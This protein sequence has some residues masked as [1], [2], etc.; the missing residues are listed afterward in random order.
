[1]LFKKTITKEKCNEIKNNLNNGFYDKNNDLIYKEI[2]E[3]V[4]KTLSWISNEEENILIK[5]CYINKINQGEFI[6]NENDLNKI[7]IIVI[8]N[9]TIKDEIIS[10]N[11]PKWCYFKLNELKF[12]FKDKKIIYYSFYENKKPFDDE[13][14]LF[15]LPHI[16]KK[17]EEEEIELFKIPD[18]KNKIPLINCE[19]NENN[20][21]IEFDY[22]SIESLFI[23][24]LVLISE[25]LILKLNYQKQYDKEIINQYKNIKKT[26]SLF[27]DKDFNINNEILGPKTNYLLDK[28]KGKKT[29]LNTIRII[30]I[31]IVLLTDLNL[32]NKI[33]YEF[34]NIKTNLIINWLNFEEFLFY[35]D[36]LLL[37]DDINFKLLLN[38][39]KSKFNYQYN[40]LKVNNQLKEIIQYDYDSINNIEIIDLNTIKIDF[41]FYIKVLNFYSNYNNNYSLNEIINNGYIY[42]TFESFLFKFCPQLQKLISY[43][44]ILLRFVSI[45]FN[46]YYK[47]YNDR[48]NLYNIY[49]NNL[50][51]NFFCKNEYYNFKS[52]LKFLTILYDYGYLKPI[53][54]LSLLLNDDNNDK[55]YII[56]NN[57]YDIKQ[58][59]NDIEDLP[60]YFP[61]CISNTL[62][63]NIHLYNYDRLTLS[64]YFKSLRLNEDDIKKLYLNNKSN[65]NLKDLITQFKSTKIK[66]FNCY[67]IFGNKN[68][69]SFKCPYKQDFEDLSNLQIISKCR[70]DSNLDHFTPIQFIYKKIVNSNK[71]EII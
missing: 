30:F 25:I 60:K 2:I 22:N 8:F 63:E 7:I 32:S 45:P 50:K 66:P 51:D 17:D 57:I 64:N 24:Y 61:P 53:D 52:I 42:L 46:N 44:D 41:L 70:E 21:D 13:E 67:S 10:L 38:D 39:I 12:S 29:F 59:I 1:M 48:Q 62:K 15:K 5:I 3:F 54:N 4:L 28:F 40:C 34:D 37:K 65:D 56:K 16:K 43:N 19:N 33:I 49:N 18:I 55:D 9:F 23:N 36:S 47:Y 71:M 20:D 27:F 26:F 11:L 69:Q 68:L 35:L 6:I 14:E 58:E 31:Q